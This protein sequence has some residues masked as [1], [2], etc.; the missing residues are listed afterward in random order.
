MKAVVLVLVLCACAVSAWERHAT[1]S[2]VGWGGTSDFTFTYEGQT[3]SPFTS[4]GSQIVVAHVTYDA[5]DPSYPDLAGLKIKCRARPATE[6]WGDHCTTRKDYQEKFDRWECT[7][8][9]KDVTPMLEVVGR[10]VMI[11][12]NAD[13]HAFVQKLYNF[14]PG[15]CFIKVTLHD[16]TM[17]MPV[18][19]NNPYRIT[20]LADDLA[21]VK[22][23][24]AEPVYAR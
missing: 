18:R 4:P 15:S 13:G 6:Y 14:I 22:P 8:E 17:P 23:P 3:S 20:A 9:S 24:C 10:S 11:C 16:H 12:E 5:A 2:P 21:G 1:H 7:V 19:V